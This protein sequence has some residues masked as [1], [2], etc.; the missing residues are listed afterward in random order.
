ML[1]VVSLGKGYAGIEKVNDMKTWIVVLVLA[2]LVG[3]GREEG[4][5]PVDVEEMP[6]VVAKA[7][8]GS[9]AIS[10]ALKH[11]IV[12]TDERLKEHVIQVDGLKFMSQSNPSMAA[13]LQE[14]TVWLE[15]SLADAHERLG[16]IRE[17]QAD[18][19][20]AMKA[21]LEALISKMDERYDV[22]MGLARGAYK[23]TVDDGEEEDDLQSNPPGLEEDGFD[24]ETELFK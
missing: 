7:A 18:Q 8:Q 16:N 9:D 19:V 2:G 3:C 6:A 5:P 11:Y 1:G 22:A 15:D 14:L 10:V 12:T 23:N 4:P 13:E 20:E 17:A 24:R 21:D